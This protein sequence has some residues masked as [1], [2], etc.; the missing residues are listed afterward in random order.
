MKAA[1]TLAKPESMDLDT[2][3]GWSKNAAAA[4][5]V[6]CCEAEAYYKVM[7]QHYERVMQLLGR[8][9]ELRTKDS[10]DGAEEAGEIVETMMEVAAAMEALR[11][12]R[13]EDPESISLDDYEA[14]VVS[15]PS[16]KSAAV[17]LDEEAKAFRE[18]YFHH[19]QR[20]GLMTQ[21]DVAQLTGIDRRQISALERGLHRPQFKTL[22]RLA[23]AFGIQ[24]TQFMGE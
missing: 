15:T 17:Q 21:E 5:H 13:Y 18:A 12:D 11:T 23:K 22:N 8:L 7:S 10:P 1:L 9:Q 2:V 14:E 3:I 19:K 24:V 16:G 20:L 4:A 6:Q